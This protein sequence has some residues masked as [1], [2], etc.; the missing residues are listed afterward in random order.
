MYPNDEEMTV[1]R[2]RYHRKAYHLATFKIV[3][4]VMDLVS[5]GRKLTLVLN[6]VVFK[7]QRCGTHDS[8]HWLAIPDNETGPKRLMLMPKSYNGVSQSL[9][10]DV[11]GEAKCCSQIEI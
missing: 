8:L 7:A 9:D 6:S 1:P 10:V 4:M 5:V 11:S 3:H 2:Q